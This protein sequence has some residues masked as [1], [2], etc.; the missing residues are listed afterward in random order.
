MQ[1]NVS[2]KWIAKISVLWES[3]S[4]SQEELDAL[5]PPPTGM[6]SVLDRAFKGEL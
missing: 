2:G 1:S 4:Q 3:Q 6:L 5:L